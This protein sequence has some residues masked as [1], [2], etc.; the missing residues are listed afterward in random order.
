M[1]KDGSM[2]GAT[3]TGRP[4]KPINEKI[5]A[6]N[7]G[8]RPLG[9]LDIPDNLDA[10]NLEGVQMPPVEDYMLSHQK[11]GKPLKA[12]EIFTKTYDWLIKLGVDRLVNSQLVSQYAM[13]VSRW[14]Q[15][16]EAISSLGF[17]AKHPTTG[18]AMTS[19]FVSMSQA[20]MKQSN[21]AW[22]QIFQIV[23]DNCTTDYSGKTPQDDV[24]EM[25]LKAR[26][27]S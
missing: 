14:I 2:R 6:G 24:M 13:S 18:A 25:L 27:R 8:H 1:A 9:I 7:P 22:M 10:P 15:C 16:E 20:Y 17:L 19:P 21:I 5:S 12:P 23:K 3:A 11:D 4:K 26:E